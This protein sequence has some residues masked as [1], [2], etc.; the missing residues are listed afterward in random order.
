MTLG[1]LKTIVE[2]DLPVKIAIMNNDAQMMVTIWER[3]FFEE[4]YTATINRKNPDFVALA[5]SYG[6][7]AMRCSSSSELD[8][9][10]D[11]F[12]NYPK[13]ILCEFKVER[14]IC[15][16]LVGPGKALDDMVLPENYD[17]KIKI[18]DGMAPS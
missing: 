9:S 7:H 16:P 15:L 17:T 8:E 5:E 11:T 13:A 10:L 2:N 6:I 4:R 18:M 3:L 1:D 12:L 14:G